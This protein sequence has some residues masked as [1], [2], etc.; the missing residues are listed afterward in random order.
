MTK[1]GDIMN[2]D[3]DIPSPEKIN[4]SQFQEKLRK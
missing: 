4:F 1:Y 3:K 2:N